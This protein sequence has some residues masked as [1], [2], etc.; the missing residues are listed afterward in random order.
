RLSFIKF[1]SIKNAAIKH[2]NGCFFVFYALSVF[3][4]YDHAPDIIPFE[5]RQ[6]G[7]VIVRATSTI[8]NLSNINY[9]SA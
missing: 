1:C 3:C 7:A 6:L 2:L 5:P 9:R 8:S 4:F